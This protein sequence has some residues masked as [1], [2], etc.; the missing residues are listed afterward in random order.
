MCLV[1]YSWFSTRLHAWAATADSVLVCCAIVTKHCYQ[2]FK[3]S[4]Q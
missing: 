1:E 2:L 3:V 4:T